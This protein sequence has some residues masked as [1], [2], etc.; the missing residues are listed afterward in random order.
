MQGC[1]AAGSELTGFRR[2]RKQS[3]ATGIAFLDLAEPIRSPDG[4]SPTCLLWYVGAERS[5]AQQRQHADATA[6]GRVPRCGVG[7]SPGECFA[8]AKVVCL[9]LRVKHGRPLRVSAVPFERA[10][11]MEIA[12]ALFRRCLATPWF[13]HV[14]SLAA[15]S[16]TFAP[17]RGD[18]PVIAV[19][20]LWSVE[21][22]CSS[23][24]SA[25][26]SEKG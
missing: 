20:P 13:L 2:T 22:V 15:A 17:D 5:E 16:P 11:F 24:S 10:A 4:V 8:T 19:P 23:R 14:A 3:P 25:M 1:A 12:R 18:R 21:Q 9:S 6:A 7:R 26:G